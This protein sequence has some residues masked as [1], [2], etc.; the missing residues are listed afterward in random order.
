M[1]LPG[2]LPGKLHGVLDKSEPIKLSV[3]LLLCAKDQIFF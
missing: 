3:F 1:S 2:T